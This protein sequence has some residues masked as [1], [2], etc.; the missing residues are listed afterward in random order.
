MLYLTAFLTGLFSSLHCVGMCGPIALALP[1]GNSV[2]FDFL[3]GRFLYNAGRI[4][5][6]S[7]LGLL[8]G[9]FGLGLKMAGFQQSVSIGAGIIILAAVLFSLITKKPF[10]NNGFLNFFSSSFI[11]KLFASTQKSS[12]F[13]IGLINGLLPCGFVYIA[14]IGAGVT[15]HAADGAL[16]MMLFGFGTLPL[17]FTVS[18]AGLFVSQKLR[19]IFSKTTP[20]L[21]IIIG[22][23]FILRGLNLGIPY[24]S[25]K[26]N[27]TTGQ[28]EICH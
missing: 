13:V 4:F 22:I 8:F 25:P 2:L 27:Y 21:A 15:Q 6:Y 20:Y 9:I 5:T 11:Q 18:V 16:F 17:M 23:L 14:L 1:K 3:M 26:I 28:T 12:L 24:V 19:N 10:G 7:L